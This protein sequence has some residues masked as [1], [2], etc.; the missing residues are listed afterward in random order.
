MLSTTTVTI[1]KSTSIP[2]TYPDDVASSETEALWSRTKLLVEAE[3]LMDV[4]FANLAL[5]LF[6]LS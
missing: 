3:D 4:V 5:K 1:E 6:I 2:V